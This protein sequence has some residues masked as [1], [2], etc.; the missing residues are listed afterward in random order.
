[1]RSFPTTLTVLLLIG[2]SRLAQADV[3]VLILPFADTG[4]GNAKW[5]EQS[6]QQSL[7]GDVA[8]GG[9]F[10]PV[11]N[12]TTGQPSSDLAAAISAAR[13]ANVPY[14]V[15]GSYQVQGD[16]LRI[17]ASAVDV[18]NM[19]FI[20]G[21]NVGR[22]TRDIF[23]ATDALGAH[24]K[25]QLAGARAV[26]GTPVDGV[27]NTP[28]N[29][30]GASA[31]SRVQMPLT[32]VP[33]SYVDWAAEVKRGGGPFGQLMPQALVVDDPLT[34]IPIAFLP[35][36]TGAPRTTTPSRAATETR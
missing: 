27:I 14:V 28:A 7:R 23:G 33:L 11:E 10:K 17:V 13:Q 6:I 3:P 22:N 4:G 8:R 35:V 12:H 36:V 20:G 18:H 32:S 2:L 25:E 1:M 31:V 21:V 24:V 29:A 16:R 5:I 30:V 9:A 19:R 15:F 26:R 34:K